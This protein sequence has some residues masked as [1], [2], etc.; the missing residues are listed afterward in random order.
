V[1]FVSIGSNRTANMEALIEHQHGLPL[2]TLVRRFLLPHK[3]LNLLG[4]ET[5]DGGTAAGGENPQLFQRLLGKPDCHILLGH[6]LLIGHPHLFPTEVSTVLTTPMNVQ[7]GVWSLGARQPYV[8]KLIGVST[9]RHPL[10]RRGLR[11]A[12]N[13]FGGHKIAP[14]TKLALLQL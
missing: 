11:L 3:E 8:K 2:G 1:K 4:K 12:Q 7:Q 14:R 6:I 10:I 5:A 9:V 13:V